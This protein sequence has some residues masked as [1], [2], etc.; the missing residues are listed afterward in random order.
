MLAIKIK[1]RGFASSLERLVSALSWYVVLSNWTQGPHR[2]RESSCCI[3][4]WLCRIGLDNRD[5]RPGWSLDCRFFLSQ[6][7]TA[8]ELRA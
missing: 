1:K 2:F 5:R 8:F 3:G 7:K 6:G 4:K